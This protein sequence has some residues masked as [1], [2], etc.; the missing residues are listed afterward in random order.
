MRRYHLADSTR[1]RCP[2]QV[3]V[4]QISMFYRLS[5]LPVAF[6]LTFP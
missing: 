1:G 4:S 3:E 2:W 6:S 5:L